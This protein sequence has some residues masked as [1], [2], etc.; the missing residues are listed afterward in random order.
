MLQALRLDRRDFFASA[1]YR[2]QIGRQL[3]RRLRIENPEIRL[4]AP[5]RSR[6]A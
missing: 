2:E 5:G 4:N 6:I 1:S 3:N